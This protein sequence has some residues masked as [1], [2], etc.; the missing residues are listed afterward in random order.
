[1]VD[2]TDGIIGLQ[3]LGGMT[4][5]IGS[6]TADVNGDAKMGMEDVVYVIEKV[7]GIRD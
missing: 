3:L 4:P 2:L 1:M 6:L 7:I 5:V